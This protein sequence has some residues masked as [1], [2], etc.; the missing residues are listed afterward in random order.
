MAPSLGCAIEAHLQYAVALQGFLAGY[1]LPHSRRDRGAGGLIVHRMC[2]KTRGATLGAL[3]CRE[4]ELLH[5][6]DDE[7]QEGARGDLRG[8]SR[9]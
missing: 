2:T 8:A 4:P 7:D 3:K 6:E 9:P 1:Q 5:D